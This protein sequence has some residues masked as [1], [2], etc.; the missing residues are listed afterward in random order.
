M[1][2]KA[3]SRRR[4]DPAAGGVLGRIEA[5]LAGLAGCLAVTGGLS[6]LAAAVL[7]GS[8]ILL[9]AVRRL[10]DA[11]MG[12][13]VFGD[14]AWAIRPILGE[15]EIVGLAV[16][17]AIFA[18][19]PWA[20]LRR[21]HIRVDLLRA[22]LGGLARS[23]L[24]LLGD[25]SIAVFAFLVFTRQWFLILDPA[26]GEAR[27]LSGLV[28]EARWS[29]ILDR[30]RLDQESQVLGLPLWPTYLVAE[31][32]ALVFLMVALFGVWQGGYAFRR[33]LADRTG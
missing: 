27:P 32:C 25:L 31:F 30:I 29:E 21:V 5:M 23:A 24:D 17:F 8:S 28:L 12:P 33:S 13:D 11:V 22:R 14:A 2:H 6:L 20:T 15:E 3:G 19:L 10:V 9:R 4:R 1:S 18:F 16:G 7:T 26:R